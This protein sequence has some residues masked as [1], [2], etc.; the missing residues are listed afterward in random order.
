MPITHT[1]PLVPSPPYLLLNY[2]PRLPLG[3]NNGQ[4]E[5]LLTLVESLR[6]T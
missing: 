6:E 2:G 4:T 3:Q 1:S 5:L